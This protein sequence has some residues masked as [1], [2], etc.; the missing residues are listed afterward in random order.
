[1]AKKDKTREDCLRDAFADGRIAF[2]DT[3]EIDGYDDIAGEFFEKIYGLDRNEVLITDESALTD[4]AGCCIPDD[5]K[6]EK[7]GEEKLKELY[8]IGRACAVEKIN[9]YYG[10]T[11][12]PH[13]Y[14]ITVFERIRQSRAVIN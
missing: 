2:G 3:D 9:K 4:F 5:A 6:T 11:V 12:D 7:N 10:I 8:D 1:M 14:L 13:E